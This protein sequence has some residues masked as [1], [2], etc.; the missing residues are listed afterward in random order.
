M[1]ACG[2]SRI[3]E[4]PTTY[5]LPEESQVPGHQSQVQY[6]DIDWIIIL[7]KQT[8]IFDYSLALLI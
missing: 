7:L 2:N 3:P 6:Q 4:I 1:T 8:I 5:E